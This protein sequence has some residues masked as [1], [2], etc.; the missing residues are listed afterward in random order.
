MTAERLAAVRCLTPRC[1]RLIT[2]RA[3]ELAPE[4]CPYCRGPVAGVELRLP[5]RPLR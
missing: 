1:A 4:I 2:R 3:I 5:N